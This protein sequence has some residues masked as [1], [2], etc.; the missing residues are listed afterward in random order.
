MELNGS[1]TTMELKKPS[2]LVGGTGM[3][4]GL[5]PCTCVVDKNSGGISQK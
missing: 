4:D 1:L 5:V 2:R 3:W